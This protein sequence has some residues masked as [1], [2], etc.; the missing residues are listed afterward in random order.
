MVPTPER[1]LSDFPL[2]HK[3]TFPQ[4]N[5]CTATMIPLLPFLESAEFSIVVDNAKTHGPKPEENQRH[6]RRSV[7]RS[8]SMPMDLDF[9]SRRR[10]RARR[11]SDSTLSR[12]SAEPSSPPKVKKPVVANPTSKL[13]ESSPS[14]TE[15][16]NPNCVLRN[17]L[18]PVRQSSRENIQ[19]SP[20]KHMR[21]RQAPERGHSL[22]PM[23]PV[24]QQS[25]REL[26]ASSP[27]DSP[28]MDTV[29]LITQALEQLDSLADIEDDLDLSP[30]IV[31]C[32][33]SV[34]L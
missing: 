30:Q 10:R 28:K 5:L 33:P 1:L 27:K 32:L 16:Q 29:Q 31:P 6:S 2:N 13:V 15:T 23:M 24:R 11:G 3:P 20:C 22:M 17:V 21:E 25:I 19:V 9:G 8:T 12:W 26:F 34:Q 7:K 18:K 14:A 4:P